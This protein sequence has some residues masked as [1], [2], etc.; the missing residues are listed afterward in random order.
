[1]LHDAAYTAFYNTY[2]DHPDDSF[3]SEAFGPADAPHVNC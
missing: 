1:M 3:C 2:V